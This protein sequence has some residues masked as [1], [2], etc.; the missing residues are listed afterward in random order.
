MIPAQYIPYTLTVGLWLTVVG[1]YLLLF[2]YLVM[3]KWRKDRNF[4]NLT[5]AL[6]FITLAVGRAFFLLYD[7]FDKPAVIFLTPNLSVTTPIIEALFIRNTW[8]WRL[9]SFWEW[10]S[11]SSI[12]LG[13]AYVWLENKWLRRTLHLPPLFAGLALLFLPGEL[14][15][16]YGVDE[17]HFLI[18]QVQAEGY[19]LLFWLGFDPFSPWFPPKWAIIYQPSGAVYLAINYVLSSLYSI[20]IPL[21]FF[22]VAWN[23]VGVIKRKALLLGTGFIFYYIGRTVQA[24]VIR[25]LL[26]EIALFVAPVIVILAL[27]LISSG[28]QYEAE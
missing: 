12:S 25:S 1:Y 18:P 19:E 15:F 28:V 8:N 20:F 22:Y 26:G 10:L 9:A 11:V 14:L 17:V 3:F 23:S 16:G 5:L 4:F 21:M 27:I 2:I 24:A 13:I 6:F 7:F